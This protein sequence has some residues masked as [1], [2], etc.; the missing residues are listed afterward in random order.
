MRGYVFVMS[1]V[2]VYTYMYLKRSFSSC[3]DYQ[4][5]MKFQSGRER[6]LADF[7]LY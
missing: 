2:H 3:G 1:I 6:L 5:M 4:M 7:V